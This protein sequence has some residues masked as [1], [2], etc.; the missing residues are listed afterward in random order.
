MSDPCDENSARHP[1]I[2][3]GSVQG[4]KAKT[5]L[6]KEGN[7][8]FPKSC[9]A[10]NCRI[11]N[12]TKLEFKLSALSTLK[13]IWQL[14]TTRL[15]RKLRGLLSDKKAKLKMRQ[16]LPFGKTLSSQVK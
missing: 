12:P 16:Y 10:K 3:Y 7:G 8:R 5:M 15:P 1:D 13:V 9:R 14:E 2:S 6:Q 11:N 4:A